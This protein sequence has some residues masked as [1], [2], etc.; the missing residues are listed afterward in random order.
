LPGRSPHQQEVGDVRARDEQHH[1]HGTE[2]D[3]EGALDIVDEQ[4]PQRRQTDR[5]VRIR[6]R[7]L[8]LEIPESVTTS[9]SE[10]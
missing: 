2:E 4:V 10:D 7:I 9:R 6:V 8:Q 1:H 5:H 3:P